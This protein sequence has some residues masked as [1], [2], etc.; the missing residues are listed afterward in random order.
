[1][2]S[3][4][5]SFRFAFVLAWLVLIIPS[6]ISFRFTFVLACFVFMSSFSLFRFASAFYCIAFILASIL[7]SIFANRHFIVCSISIM[8][9]YTTQC[10]R[11]SN[12]LISLIQ[13]V[14]LLTP[15]VMCRS[16]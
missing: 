15:V 7:V 9:R 10:N 11:K 12:S 16:G 6:F 1:L 8:W 3:S 13:S 14:P 2:I 4:L 5:I